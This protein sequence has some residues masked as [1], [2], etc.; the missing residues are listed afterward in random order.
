ME[1]S[2]EEKGVR[3]VEK[4]LLIKVIEEDEG[5]ELFR[6]YHFFQELSHCLILEREAYE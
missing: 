1:V 4:W 6:R 5:V 2:A 3:V